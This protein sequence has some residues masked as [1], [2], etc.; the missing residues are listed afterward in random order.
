MSLNIDALQYMLTYG[1]AKTVIFGLILFLAIKI[2]HIITEFNDSKLIIENNTAMG[3]SLFGYLSAV[4]LILVASTFSREYETIIENLAVILIFAFFGILFLS[5]NRYFVNNFY[6][7][8]MEAKKEIEKNNVAFAIFQAGGFIATGVIIYNSFYGFEFTLGLITI[9][10][11]YFVITQ[12]TMFVTAK[13][14]IA[15]TIYDDLKEIHNNNIAV[16]IENVS[17]LIA[18]SFLF[19][20][21]VKETVDVDLI[22]FLLVLFYFI[23]STTFLIFVPKL[24]AS[25]LTYK[26]RNGKDIEV[27]IAENNIPIAIVSASSKIS[28]A[29]LGMVVIPFDIIYF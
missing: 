3:I 8:G 13:I 21:V 2:R 1:F 6:L 18:L 14:F 28:M 16:A 17:L 23:V 9:S 27:L 5:L 11:V 10:L 19:G 24:L 29:I 22:N 26:E 25:L 4:A 12:I 20:N 15:K 7:K